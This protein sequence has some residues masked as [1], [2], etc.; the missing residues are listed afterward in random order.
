MS[1]LEL[2]LVNENANCTLYTIQFASENDS[3]FERFYNKFKEDAE[4]V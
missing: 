2:I 3:E 1:K 4:F